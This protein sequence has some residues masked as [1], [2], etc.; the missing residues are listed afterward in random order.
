MLAGVGP[1]AIETG[2]VRAEN[3]TT[4]V[5]I[6]NVNTQTLIEAVIQTPGG[7]V[8]YAG[9][10]RIDG[11]TDPAAAIKLT[12]LDALGAVTGKL[13][14]TGSPL[15]RIDGIEATT[16]C[17]SRRRPWKSSFPSRCSN[18]R[19]TQPRSAATSVL[20]LPMP[21]AGFRTI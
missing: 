11:V 18:P 1:F 19:R 8:E 7:Q 3:P 6:Y 17:V 13:L 21:D 10:T 20:R 2:L 9:D 12:F 5:R 15:D 4:K 14:P 16:P